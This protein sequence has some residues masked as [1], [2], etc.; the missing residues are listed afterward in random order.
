MFAQTNKIM[1]VENSET[2]QEKP[3]EKKESYRKIFSNVLRT[4][5]QD[6]MKVVAVLMPGNV[7]IYEAYEEAIEQYLI[8]KEAE[9]KITPP[10]P[11]VTQQ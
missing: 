4:D 11:A 2:Q 9:L 8:K 5:L 1:G 6:R 7:K 3:E 10:V